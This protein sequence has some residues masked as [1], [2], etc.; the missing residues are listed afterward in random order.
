MTLTVGGTDS[1][2]GFLEL[3]QGS[4][5]AR[6]VLKVTYRPVLVVLESSTQRQAVLVQV[7]QQSSTDMEDI[8]LVS[9]V[10]SES[11]APNSL[12]SKIQVRAC[13]QTH[14]TFQCPAAH[15]GDLQQPPD[16]P[17]SV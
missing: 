1:L 5:A 6:L 4:D 8:N 9:C 7:V 3:P 11:E 10:R 15:G 12:Q 13:R 17:V 16:V 14:L 2:P